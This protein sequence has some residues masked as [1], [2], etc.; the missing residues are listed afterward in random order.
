VK[1]HCIIIGGGLAGLTC[2][3]RCAGAGLRTAVIS[4]GASALHA[5]SGSIDLLK[6]DDNKNKS[7][8]IFRHIKEFT[9][10]RPDHPYSMVGVKRIEETIDFI[11][12]ELESA[13]IILNGLGKRNHLHLTALGNAKQTYLS[14]RS[15]FSKGLYDAYSEPGDAAVINFE[16]FRDFFPLLAEK[17][18][19][20]NPL[21][22]KKKLSFKTIK[23]SGYADDREDHTEFRSI[24]LARIFDTEKYIPRLAADIAEQAGSA[25]IVILPGFIGID[26]YGRILS[27]LEELT[28]KFIVEVPNLPPSIPG[29]RLERGLK[30]ILARYGGELT[31]GKVTG[32]SI[33]DGILEYIETGSTPGY[34]YISDNYLLATGSFF[35]GGLSAGFRDISEPVFGLK[36]TDGGKRKSWYSSRF[37][38]SEG[39]PFME[40][41][42]KTER[43]LN[44]LNSNSKRVKNLF[45][46]GAVLSG[47]DPV[48]ESSGGGVAISTGYYAAE[49]IIKRCKK[50]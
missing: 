8:N 31:P 26:N 2:G 44:P 13:G 50:K 22:K 43:N 11:K 3:I 39:H 20:D 4:N 38:G 45:C 40:F 41:G 1:Y 30:S 47:Y 19:R 6:T 23:L 5:A 10:Q 29:M 49:Q 17:R 28:G 32:G 36:V 15:L 7:G 21:L 27:R 37:T 33:E 18:F 35:S 16:E 42:V 12:G 14:Q 9:A 34:R 25:G 48:R 24:D 46:A